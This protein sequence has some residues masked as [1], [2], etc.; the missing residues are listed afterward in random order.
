MLHLQI[1]RRPRHRQAILREKAV[2]VQLLVPSGAPTSRRQQYQSTNEYRQRAETAS[3][4]AKGSATARYNGSGRR[5]APATKTSCGIRS[6]AVKP[7]RFS[8]SAASGDSCSRANS[9]VVV[10]VC[11]SP[12]SQFLGPAYPTGG[13]GIDRCIGPWM[14]RFQ[15]CNPGPT[16]GPAIGF[17][18]GRLVGLPTLGRS[19]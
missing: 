19:P 6:D 10:T 9:Q 17:P 14:C 7:Q 1:E 8:R 3:P 18:R 5:S 4:K 12:G 2:H 13:S 11:G 16:L 15:S